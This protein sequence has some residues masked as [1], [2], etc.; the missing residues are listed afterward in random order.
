M[1]T[2]KGEPEW[3]INYIYEHDC[4]NNTIYKVY[5]DYVY[6]FSVSHDYNPYGCPFGSINYNLVRAKLLER[7]GPPFKIGFSTFGNCT[8]CEF[9][10]KQRDPIYTL[11]RT[12]G[13]TRCCDKCLD[14]LERI[15]LLE[16]NGVFV[17]KDDLGLLFK[18][19]AAVIT[20]TSFNTAIHHVS[21]I[22][23]PNLI[24]APYRQFNCALCERK[25]LVEKYCL[26]CI[27]YSKQEFIDNH[28][29]VPTTVRLMIGLD[30]LSTF[31]MKL[32]FK[33]KFS[34]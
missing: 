31:I 6:I 4:H 29:I 10:G 33:L 15:S 3:D 9:C 5:N 27:N 23:Y 34:H 19:D 30:D 20:I 12:N 28:W 16:R 25:G 32:W 7:K 22:E 13:R 24:S 21:A 8:D 2:S 18:L 14:K 11:K 26:Q 1:I 17:L